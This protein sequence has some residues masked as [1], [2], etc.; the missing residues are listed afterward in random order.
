MYDAGQV[1]LW[2]EELYYIVP[3]SEFSLESVFVLRKNKYAMIQ[4]SIS[5]THVYND[6][7]YGDFK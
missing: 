1:N 7:R 5:V 4:C 3:L 6:N 2:G